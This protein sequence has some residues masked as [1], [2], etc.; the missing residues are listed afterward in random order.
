M[1]RPGPQPLIS[2]DDGI[3]KDDLSVIRRN[4]AE[5]NDH[6]TPHAVFAE[7]QERQGT[8]TPRPLAPTH[9]ARNGRFR[10]VNGSDDDSV[11][12]IGE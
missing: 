1:N 2:D 6:N 7:E 9:E 5:L 3:S 4:L 8:P 10:V 12:S 11:F